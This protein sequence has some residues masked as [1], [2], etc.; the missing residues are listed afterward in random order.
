MSK[1]KD[2]SGLIKKNEYDHEKAELFAEACTELIEIEK[3]AKYLKQLITENQNLQPF[4]WTTLQGEC[5]PL[6]KIE[7]DHLRNILG[8]IIKRGGN[9]PAEIKAEA[10]SRNIEVPDWEAVAAR[11]LLQAR[12]AEII[13]LED[14]AH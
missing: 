13:E 4:T 6:H 11:R 9:I 2:Y 10:V 3:R 12:E 7:D 5:K 14:L 1:Y 8:H